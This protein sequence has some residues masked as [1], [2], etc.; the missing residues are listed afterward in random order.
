MKLQWITVLLAA[1][2]TTPAVAAHHKAAAH[3]KNLSTPPK[4]TVSSVNQAAP[5]G[6]AEEPSLIVKAEVLLDR[7]HFSPGEIDGKNGENFR[8]AV[9]AF[10][11]A[12]DLEVTARINAD[13]WKALTSNFSEAALT[14]YT[15]LDEDVSG[16][17]DKQT[18]RNLD[19]MAKLQGL[20]YK[21]P[22]EE[23]AEKFHMSEDLL[24]R[25]NPDARFDRVG[26]SIAVANVEPMQLR[27][28]HESTVE[29]AP[30]KKQN[31]EGERVAT[32][33][34]DKATSDV[35]A[36]NEAGNLVAFYPATIGSEEKPAPTGT[37]KVRRVAYNPDYHYNPK[38]AWKGVKADHDLTIK[39]GPNNPVGL[40]W[41]DLTAP[42]YGIHGTPEPKN[43]SKTQS[44]GCVR[45][46]NWD[47][48]DLAGMVRRGTLVK[49]EDEDIPV[50]PLS[51]SARATG[52]HQAPAAAGSR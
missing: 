25:L 41:I 18:P 23:L 10:Q 11:Q 19:D 42:S 21:E 36:Y 17:F 5:S 13:T 27:Q 51:A 8:K 52:T 29:A 35:R 48:L 22:L 33:V 3:H 47:A 38:F 26:D 6:N 14:S 34:V 46:T 2:S 12:N 4:M 28:G 39:P 24:R 32:I 20:S 1:L 9:K 15:I 16:P 44:H 31:A 40:V 45:L 37:F 7:N 30:P 50:V 49:F 43:I